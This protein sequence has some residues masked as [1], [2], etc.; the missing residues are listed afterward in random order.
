MS[1]MVI[2]YQVS[3]KETP[4]EV[5]GADVSA[6]YLIIVTTATTGGSVKNFK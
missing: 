2:D 3:L 5:G 1:Q 6:A 4:E